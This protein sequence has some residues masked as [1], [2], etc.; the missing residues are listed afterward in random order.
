MSAQ[1]SS[2]DSVD[3]DGDDGDD[4]DDDDAIFVVIVIVIF[5][6]ANDT[7]ATVV[8]V[9]DDISRFFFLL[10]MLMACMPSSQDHSRI[11]LYPPLMVYTILLVYVWVFFLFF[12]LDWRK[13]YIFFGFLTACGLFVGTNVICI[14]K[15]MALLFGANA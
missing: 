7:T 5:S 14:L 3:D 13:H 12:S 15:R 2:F 11:S 6:D 4:G 8:V 10:L 9:D 1:S